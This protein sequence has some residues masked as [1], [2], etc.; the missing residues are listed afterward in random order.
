MLRPGSVEGGAR[1]PNVLHAQ[2]MFQ[3]KSLSVILM[4]LSFFLVSNAP[5]IG[6]STTAAPSVSRPGH[7]SPQGHPDYVFANSA[8]VGGLR[9][10][11]T[12]CVVTLAAAHPLRH[13]L[14]Q[15]AVFKQS[16]Y[17]SDS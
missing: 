2:P 14:K 9:V 17:R 8:G 15:S 11:D 6:K 16:H 10:T 5:R 12:I 7:A 4:S 13:V 1:G 3:L